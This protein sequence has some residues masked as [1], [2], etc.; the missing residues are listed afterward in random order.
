MD[1]KPKV[2][3]PKKKKFK[4]TRQLINLALNDGWVQKQIAT[5]C[6][7]HQSVVSNWKS[8]AALA[9]EAQLSP[10]L[11]IYGHKLRRNS[12]RMY[13]SH[14]PDTLKVSFHKV[15]GIVIFSQSF[16][17]PRRQNW[18]LIKHIPLH[19]LVIHDQGRGL[20]RVVQQ[21]RFNLEPGNQEL[22]CSHEDAIWNSTIGHQVDVT[23]LMDILYIYAKETLH[24]HKSDAI[25]LP[26]LIRKALLNHGHQVDGIVEYPAVW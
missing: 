19:K 8:G 11:E 13:W 15:E 3:S 20:F 25:T 18:K 7:V 4:Q 2:A 5:T 1:T 6:R 23:E 10:L 9:T 24:S 16:T 12:F 22:E 14:D 26:F 17:D 21:S